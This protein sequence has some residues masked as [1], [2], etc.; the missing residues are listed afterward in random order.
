MKHLA[1]L[2]YGITLGLLLC[3]PAR[4]QVQ[5]TDPGWPGMPG[6]LAGPVCMPEDYPGHHYYGP[7]V[8]QIP[9]LPAEYDATTIVGIEFV[10]VTVTRSTV[11]WIENLSDGWLAL[12]GAMCRRI[13]PHVYLH[14]LYPLPGWSQ[15]EPWVSIENYSVG[16]GI[17]FTAPFDGRSDGETSYG[18]KPG[19]ASWTTRGTIWA[20]D[21][22]DIYTPAPN[23]YAYDL[24]WFYGVDG[25][26]P[27][28]LECPT[29][30]YFQDHA[31]A[32]VALPVYYE[33]R[34]GAG[35]DLEAVRY[36]L[37]PDRLGPLAEYA[38]ELTI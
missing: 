37:D 29:S 23:S 1:Y 3:A 10:G 8:F 20:V 17:G 14:G 2:L 27:L 6:V 13:H 25:A 15:E 38:V 22:G 24:G 11:A 30:W 35:I 33:D 26:I 4:G 21:K 18:A 19:G 36:W 5:A 31:G 28:R 34:V 9:A 7:D 16:G 32:H 12:D